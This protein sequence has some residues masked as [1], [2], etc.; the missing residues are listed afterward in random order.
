MFWICTHHR[1]GTV[2]MRNVF[3]RYA[4][5]TNRPFFKGK[6]EQC[7]EGVELYQDAHSH[8]RLPDEAHGIHLF[9]DPYALLLSHVRYHLITESPGEPPNAVVM[10]DGRLY[11]EHLREKA[12]LEEMAFFELEQIYR[13]TLSDMLAWDY[14]DA[15]FINVPLDAFDNSGSAIVV[16]RWLRARFDDFD[17]DESAL[18]DAFRHVIANQ[19]LK[20]R[21]GTRREGEDPQRLLT[22]AVTDYMQREF[23]RLQ[24]LQRR[25][26]D[27][28]AEVQRELAASADSSGPDPRAEEPP[29]A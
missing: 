6:Y 18:E 16:A 26:E 19:P 11:G 28:L 20:R 24:D 8:T 14:S 22:P 7:P 15:R 27:A 21:H 17:A 23:P 4:A 29:T 9:R 1:S 10:S 3:Q 13:L 12:S 2:L 5:L 25:A